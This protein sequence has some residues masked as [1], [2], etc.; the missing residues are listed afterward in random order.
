MILYYSENNDQ[1]A[2]Y[3][4][5]KEKIELNSV[6]RNKINLLLPQRNLI[7]KFDDL[8]IVD[9][10]SKKKKPIILY[11]FSNCILVSLKLK[12]IHKTSYYGS[13]EFHENSLFMRK[14]ILNIIQTFSRQLV[15][16][17][18]LYLEQ[19]LK[20]KEIM[21]LVCVVITYLLF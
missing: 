14:Q 5:Q 2:L 11:L 15:K 16:L 6:F 20:I 18:D 19:M 4:G 21:S 13:T 12:S 1:M 7:S 9:I 17:H 10:N 8:W 3:V